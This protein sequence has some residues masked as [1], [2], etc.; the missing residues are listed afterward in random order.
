MAAIPEYLAKNFGPSFQTERAMKEIQDAVC[1]GIHQE[2][3]LLFTDG[4]PEARTR[5][6]QP[7]P[8]R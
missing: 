8:S 2:R 1:V 5:A 3:K 6:A 7:L 4:L